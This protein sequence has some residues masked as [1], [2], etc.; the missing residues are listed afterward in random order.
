MAGGLIVQYS[1]ARYSFI[2]YAIVAFGGMLTAIAMDK[3]LEM[4][5]HEETKPD[6]EVQ[7]VS[8][9]QDKT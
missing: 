2:M 8:I 6:S 9:N 3:S 4:S 1:K 5:E 7:L